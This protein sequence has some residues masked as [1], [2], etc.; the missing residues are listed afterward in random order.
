[1]F[2]IEMR[3]FGSECNVQM[4]SKQEF[5]QPESLERQ[6]KRVFSTN[7]LRGWASTAPELTL[8]VDLA[9]R[10]AGAEISSQRHSDERRH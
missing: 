10:K 5:W 8:H 1:M 2:W 3:E 6:Q 4:K 9:A 7:P